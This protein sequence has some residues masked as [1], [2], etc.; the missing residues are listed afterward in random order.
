VEGTLPEEDSCRETEE[1]EDKETYVKLSVILAI[2]R[3]T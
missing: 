1:E 3:D 2:K